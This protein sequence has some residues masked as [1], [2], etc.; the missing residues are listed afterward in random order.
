MHKTFVIGTSWSP[1]STLHPIQ[2]LQEG[3]AIY[4]RVYFHVPYILGAIGGSKTRV[5]HGWHGPVSTDDPEVTP[6]NT[7]GQDG[8][9]KAWENLIEE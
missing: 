3:G 6:Q 5:Y 4:F 7:Y 2:F 8:F 1:N 9:H